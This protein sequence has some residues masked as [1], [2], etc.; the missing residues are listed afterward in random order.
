M[1]IGFDAKRA[2]FNRTGLGNYSRSLLAGLAEHFPENRY[3]LFSPKTEENPLTA[4]IHP[5]KGFHW[6]NYRGPF[7]GLWRSQGVVRELRKQKL[8]LYHGLS[9]EIPVG[10]RRTGIRSVVSFHDLIIYRYPRQYAWLDRQ[11]YHRKLLYASQNADRIVAI[12]EATR[13]DIME[14][15]LV[16]SSRVQVIY[17]FCS[18]AFYKVLGAEE[19]KRIQEKYQLPAEF[20]LYVGSIIPRKNLGGIVEALSLLSE[21]ERLPL[22]VIG[23]GKDYADQVW[24]QARALGLEKQV[25]WKNEIAFADFPAV[26][27]QAQMMIYPSFYEGFGLPVL[28]A[29]ASGLPVITSKRASLPEAGG[30]GAICVEPDQPEAIA[31]GIRQLL[32]D[33]SLRQ[34]RIEKGKAHAR[35]FL[36]E[37]LLP[38]WIELYQELISR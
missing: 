36:P 27:Q 28:E 29:L 26:Y 38:Q 13:K 11:I 20:L 23:A 9:H 14:F 32:G 15:M 1:R 6:H 12:S 24:Q 34:E 37:K 21:G 8:D 10:L 31:E 2:F 5:A 25:L 3:H 17:Q 33:S 16:P 18:P 7:P 19:K 35:E 4:D 22:V 30:P